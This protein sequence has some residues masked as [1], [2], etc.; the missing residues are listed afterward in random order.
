MR[1]VY[2]LVEATNL[3]RRRVDQMAAYDTTAFDAT[4]A[5]ADFAQ[6]ADFKERAAIINLLQQYVDELAV[7]S[8][9]KDAAGIDDESKAAAASMGALAKTGLPALTHAK[10]AALSPDEVT[11]A[12]L[13]IDALGR[14]L[15]ERQRARAL[16][17]IVTD[18]NS[19]VATLCTLLRED[20]GDPQ[21]AGLRMVLRVDYEGM[22]TAEDA[23]IRDHPREYSYPEKRAAVEG[24]YAL[25]DQ[26]AA[27]DL[28]LAKTDDA[29][30][31]LAKAHAALAASARDHT[32]PAFRARLL[33]LKRQAGQL[34]AL[35][36]T[37][38]AGSKTVAASAK[39][40]PAGK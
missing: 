25:M 23:A 27:A 20:I 32:A 13:A 15:L 35:Q 33:E 5:D 38:D 16:P 26:Q 2:T 11:A 1:A 24:L 29:L 18:A 4:A 12:G 14:V 17:A 7:V 34:E 3:R 22:E 30:A 39:A 9:D 40:A 28:T 31:E 8:G 10:H 36:Q 37:M 21:S 19:P 6:A